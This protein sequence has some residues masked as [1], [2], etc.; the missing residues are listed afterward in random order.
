MRRISSVFLAL[1]CAAA[2]ACNGDSPLSPT[3][4][5]LTGTWSGTGTYPNAP[6]QVVLTQTGTTLRGEYSDQHDR[7]T[8]VSG[9]YTNPAFT[10]SVNFGDGGLVLNGTLVTARTAQGTMFTPSLGNQLFTFSM[11]R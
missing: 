2:A 6:F 10:I 8:S 4:S 5:D 9:S 7:S 11:A 1:A 3:V